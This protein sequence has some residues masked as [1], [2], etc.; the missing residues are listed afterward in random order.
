[1]AIAGAQCILISFDLDFQFELIEFQAFSYSRTSNLRI[2]NSST[3]QNSYL[4]RALSLDAVTHIKAQFPFSQLLAIPCITT[5]QQGDI[6]VCQQGT[7]KPFWFFGQEMSNEYHLRRT[8]CKVDRFAGGTFISQSCY[9][10]CKLQLKKNNVSSKPSQDSTKLNLVY[11]T[12]EEYEQSL[13]SPFLRVHWPHF[14]FNCR[15]LQGFYTF[16]SIGDE[17]NTH[18]TEEKYITGQF[19]EFHMINT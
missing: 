11:Y 5:F 10:T 13:Y 3:N 9:H 2:K 17:Y 7:C 16:F 19:L 15:L 18:Q 1:M 4:N 12:L 6:S 14:Y 8:M